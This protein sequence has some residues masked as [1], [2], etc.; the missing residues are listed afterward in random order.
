M[1]NRK[2]AQLALGLIALIQILMLFSCSTKNKVKPTLFRNADEVPRTIAVLPF[3][4]SSNTDDIDEK[5]RSSI[6]G[7]MAVLNY[8]DLE[9]WE[10][11][12]RLD[13]YLQ[14]T[15][16]RLEELSI[17]EIGFILNCDAV[18]FGE[19]TVARKLFLGLYAQLAVGACIELWDTRS[20]EMI[21]ADRHVVRYHKGGL[22]TEPV[23]LV[24]TG[25]GT[26]TSLKDHMRSRAI[27][28]LSRHLIDNFPQPEYSRQERSTARLYELQLA[29]F[30]TRDK[31]QELLEELKMAEYSAFIRSNHDARGLWY[32]VLLGPFTTQLEAEQSRKELAQR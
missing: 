19:I 1:K 15:G 25:Y 8:L 5:V 22:P 13:D 20:G 4:N 31:A 17:E 16:R 18:V 24:V 6:A 11:D 27:D 10:V 12:L 32:R 26:V 3:R 2:T 21:W 28:E 23:G 30:L 9:L 14:K 29:A 7:H